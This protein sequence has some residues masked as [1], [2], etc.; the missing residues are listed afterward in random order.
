MDF[1]ELENED[2]DNTSEENKNKFV[3]VEIRREKDFLAYLFNS[4]I[5]E[6]GFICGGYARYVCSDP[7]ESG[8]REIKPAA[9]LDIYCFDE[10]AYKRIRSR[11]EKHGYSALRENDI[12]ISMKIGFDGFPA[13]QLI[14]P[15]TA[16]RVNTSGTL[17]E[18]LSN[19]D[20][21][22]ARCGIF[23]EFKIVEDEN[24]MDV[25]T[26]ILK[27][28]A[29]IDFP[30]DEKAN[31]LRIKHIHCP[32]AEFYRMAKY[33]NKGFSVSTL[34]IIKTLQDWEERGDDYKTKIIE[35]L[36]KDE[37]TTEEITEMEK[38]LHID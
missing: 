29:D 14:K 37:P 27:A 8:K 21:S 7:G 3:P 31:R 22:V 19:F 4:I 1:E 5:Q 17:E 10:E 25:S 23:A 15:F 13:M 24:G 12:A 34:E 26:A 30:E 35:T 2:D 18:V 11:M 20:F 28:I 38:L 36:K 32:I 6:D 9:D 16:D 33:M